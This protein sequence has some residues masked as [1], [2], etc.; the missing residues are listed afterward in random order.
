MQS[1]GNNPRFWLWNWKFLVRILISII[2]PEKK[3]S[4]KCPGCTTVAYAHKYMYFG[5]SPDYQASG[6][7]NKQQQQKCSWAEMDSCLE[8]CGLP[9]QSQASSR[10]DV[11]QENTT[12]QSKWKSLIHLSSQFHTCAVTECSLMKK[13]SCFFLGGREEKKKNQSKSTRKVYWQQHPCYKGT[14]RICLTPC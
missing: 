4:S 8:D 14:D 3:T 5:K 12:C 7:R 10:Q 1:L 13:E 2:K 6:P 11:F 9:W